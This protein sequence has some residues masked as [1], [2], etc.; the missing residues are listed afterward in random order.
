MKKENRHIS[1]YKNNVFAKQFD[2]LIRE[3]FTEE[4]H[5]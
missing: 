5:F 1:F 2:E 4:F 3:K